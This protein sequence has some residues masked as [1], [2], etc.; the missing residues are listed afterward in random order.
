MQVT[1]DVRQRYFARISLYL[2]LY[3]VQS[4]SLLEVTRVYYIPDTRGYLCVG[5]GMLLILLIDTTSIV[6][7][8]L[9]HPPHVHTIHAV[10]RWVPPGLVTCIQLPITALP[11]YRPTLD[12]VHATG[13]CWLATISVYTNLL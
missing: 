10:A 6:L 11:V 8:I 7:V 9:A 4:A 13:T 1:A 5:M 2:N 3:S 12:K